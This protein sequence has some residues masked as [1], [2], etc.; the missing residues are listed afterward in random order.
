MTPMLN[1][2]QNETRKRG[3][4]LDA[5]ELSHITDLENP[6]PHIILCIDE[7]ALLRKEKAIMAIVEE[8]SAISRALGIFL[9]LSMQR[10]D[11]KLLEGALKN[12][13]TVRM[14]FKCADLINSQIIGTPDSEKLKVNGRMLLKLQG[15]GDVKE[16]QAPYLSLERAKEILHRY[17]KNPVTCCNTVLKRLRRDGHIEVNTNQQPYIYFSSPAPIKKD[18]AKIPHFLKIVEFYKSQLKVEYPKS[19]IVEPKYG[20]GNMEPDAFMIWKR[21]PFFVEIQRSIYSDKVM[22]EK[23]NRYMSYYTSN[24]WKEE[25]WQPADRKVFPKIILITDTKY[26]LSQ[27]SA[28]HFF[29]VQNIIQFVNIF[30]SRE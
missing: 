3:D 9:I 16:I 1:Y 13:L 5:H 11:A 25:P 18:S 29:Q 27:H 21:A 24:E 15:Q 2:L 14:G 19:F 28:V 8:I 23:F 10:P 7:V 20:K 22:N 30:T 4:L 26:N 17:L 6:P 12:N